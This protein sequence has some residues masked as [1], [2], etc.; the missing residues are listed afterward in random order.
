M[1]KIF[2]ILTIVCAL[3][4]GSTVVNANNVT[5]TWKA[6]KAI[7]FD[8]DGNR[9]SF[10]MESLGVEAMI[11]FSANNTVELNFDG[12]VLSS[13][14]QFEGNVLFITINDVAVGLYTNFVDENTM[15]MD[16]SEFIGENAMFVFEKVGTTKKAT[17]TAPY[18][19]SVNLIGTWKGTSGV[20]SSDG[21]EISLDLAFLG[22][23][24][25]YTF[26][27]NG[28]IIATVN[29]ESEQGT[30]QFDGKELLVTFDGETNSL[31]IEFVS[32]NKFFIFQPI[33]YGEEKPDSV[34][35][36]FF[37]RQ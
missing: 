14:Y 13:T 6:T 30:Y 31:P 10:G 5:G 28:Q 27:S 19:G 25:S 35:K 16:W 12:K 4:L 1:K 26:K 21:A 9:A 2:S 34:V 32:A 15:E 29:N 37:E 36:L 24:M 33:G 22:I 8:D 18:T 23:D 17:T 20:G 11:T 3:F 7:V